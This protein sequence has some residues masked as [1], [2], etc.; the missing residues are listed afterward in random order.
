MDYFAH[1]TD[2]LKTQPLE[3]HLENTGELAASFAEVMNESAV[4]RMLGRLHDLGKYGEQWQNYLKKSTGYDPSIPDESCKRGEHSTAGAA[5]L[6]KNMPQPESLFLAYTILGHHAGLPDFYDGVGESLLSRL[7]ENDYLKTESLDEINFDDVDVPEVAF[8]SQ[9]IGDMDDEYVHLWIRMIFSAL[10]DADDLDTEK[11]M[12]SAKNA[13]RGTSDSRDTLARLK[14]KFD[15]YMEEKCANAP[16]T[17]VNR[18][19]SEILRQCIEAA[20][21]PAGF[22]SLT[23]P[24]G[25]GKTLSAMAFALAHAL[26]NDKRRVVMAIPYTSIIEQTAKTYKYGTDD[27]EA[28]KTMKDRGECLFGEENV[29]EHHSNVEPVKEGD[30][31]MDW[32]Y[33]AAQ[34]WDAPVVVTTNVQLFESLLAAKPSRCRKLHN[35]AHSVIILDEA[36]KIPAEHL[37]PVLSVLKGLVRHFGVTVLFCTATQPALTGQ[38]GSFNTRM[39]G[40]S[41]C[42]E[43]IKNPQ[44]LCEQLKRVEYKVFKDDIN[45]RS[46]WEEVAEE[47]K[48]VP[49]VLCV[50]NKRRDCRELVKLMP[51][52][53]IELSGFMCGE[54]ISSIITR[55]KRLLKEGK[56]VRVV[57]TQLVESGVDIDF[58]EVWRAV[59]QLD[60]IV[61]AAGR[62]NREGKLKDDLGNPRFGKVVVFRPES[63]P[64]GEIKIGTQITSGL[65][66]TAEYFNSLSDESFHSYFKNF[67]NNHQTLDKCDYDGLL[68]NEASCAR[69]K[70]RSFAERFKIVDTSGQKTVFVQYGDGEKLVKQLREGFPDRRLMSK[71]QRFSVNIPANLFNDILQKGGIEVVNNY[72]VLDKSFY[73]PGKGVLVNEF[74]NY[75]DHNFIY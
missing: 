32:H 54:E 35:L 63:E 33:L 3:E 20:R 5:W 23:V 17:P 12:D 50:V 44:R 10:V 68:V 18:V 56:P 66:S 47:L 43:I 65:A 36:Q 29:L 55:I 49:Q 46:S 37:R 41:D 27:D 75:D 71:L 9:E 15:S 62:A 53:T 13:K 60:S 31:E 40:I 19:R 34:N 69:M 58:P 74:Y 59:A 8:P 11:F 42:K 52:G 7:F 25:G 22:Y 4:A 24:T 61:Q 45:A 1:I 67:Y 26:K 14:E 16:Q 72:Y 64:F 2:D 39:E 21:G 70:F 38:I 51:E 28:I 6:I 30:M 57:S 48:K 73:E